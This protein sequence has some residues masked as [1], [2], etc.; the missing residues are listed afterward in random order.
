LTSGAE[1]FKPE[2]HEL[3]KQRD[4]RF[5]IISC[6]IV[7]IVFKDD[8]SKGRIGFLGEGI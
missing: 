4:E 1:A 3:P 6:A 5:R 8:N 2:A 7:L